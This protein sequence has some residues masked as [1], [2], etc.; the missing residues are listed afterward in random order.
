MVTVTGN[1]MI[2]LKKLTF[3]VFN[4]FICEILLTFNVRANFN[5]TFLTIPKILRCK[6]VGDFCN[7]VGDGNT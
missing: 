3:N 5:L 1:G 6:G 2:S 4:A 7:E